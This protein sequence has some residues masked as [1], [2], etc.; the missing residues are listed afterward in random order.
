L[1]SCRAWQQTFFYVKNT[2]DADLINLPVY[3]PGAPSRAN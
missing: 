2:S 1:E 3:V